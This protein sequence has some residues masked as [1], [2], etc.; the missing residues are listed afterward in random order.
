[1]KLGEHIEPLRP[2]IEAILRQHKSS[3]ELRSAAG[4][5]VSFMVTTPRSVRTDRVSQWLE[6]R[7]EVGLIVSN[8]SVARKILQV[9]EG[10]WKEA[11]K[12]S[13]KKDA[14]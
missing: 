11:G 6:N 2:Q 5:T 9:F 13:K 4:D 7:R 12:D 3:Y 8:P 10:G 1:M 14:A